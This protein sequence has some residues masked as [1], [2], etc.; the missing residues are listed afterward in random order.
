[1][2]PVQDTCI[3]FLHQC[4]MHMLTFSTW[5]YI[6][7]MDNPDL[8]V[9]QFK[10]VT[11]PLRT[12]TMGLDLSWIHGMLLQD[13]GFQTSVQLHHFNAYAKVRW[14]YTLLSPTLFCI[15]FNPKIII[16]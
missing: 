16:N 11:I 15:K 10:I 2:E 8:H 9:M 12:K 6:R 4:I 13:A 1:M 5:Y 14:N 7:S 3:V